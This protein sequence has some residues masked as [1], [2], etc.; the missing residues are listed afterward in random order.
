MMQRW[1]LI[2]IDMENS[3]TLQPDYA[4]ASLYY[5]AFLAKHFNNKSLSDEFSCWWPDWYKYSRDTL[6]NGVVYGDMVLFRPNMTP[7]S[8]TYIQWANTVTLRPTSNVLLGL[9]NFEA[10]SSSSQTRNNIAGIHWRELHDI[11]TKCGILPPTTGSLTFNASGPLQ[12]T[13]RSR[14]RKNTPSFIWR[15]GQSIPF[16][17]KYYDN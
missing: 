16:Y 14:K 15:G 1:F 2:Q 4:I 12:T 6:S 8:P 17:H 10:I 11:C 3:A 9:F 13:S 7:R 5:C